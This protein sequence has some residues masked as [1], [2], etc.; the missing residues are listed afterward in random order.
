MSLL[1]YTKWILRGLVIVASQNLPELD[2][3]PSSFI[4]YA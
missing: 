3:P 2:Y 1:R 4:M